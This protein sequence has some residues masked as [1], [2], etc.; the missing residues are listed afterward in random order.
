MYMQKQ[1]TTTS[2]RQIV[3]LEHFDYGLELC[4]KQLSRLRLLLRT[5]FLNPFSC[6]VSLGAFSCVV[7]SGAFSCVVSLGAFSC[8]VSLGAF[9]CVVSLGAFSCVVHWVPFLV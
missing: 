3:P 9:S 7:S 4:S 1:L 6:V 8:V 2:S 5:K